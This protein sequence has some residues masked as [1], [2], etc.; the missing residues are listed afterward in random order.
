MGLSFTKKNNT[1]INSAVRMKLMLKG[2]TYQFF[3]V[4]R[5]LKIKRNR[6][7]LWCAVILPPCC[8][9][10]LF[11]LAVEKFRQYDSR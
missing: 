3:P 2:K 5:C 8:P 11:L 1:L 9:K 6:C 4:N 10:M 7:N